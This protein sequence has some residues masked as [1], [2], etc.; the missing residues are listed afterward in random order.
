MSAPTNYQPLFSLGELSRA[1]IDFES[2]SITKDGTLFRS[3]ETAVAELRSKIDEVEKAV[4]KRLR[5]EEA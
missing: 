4:Q 1:L 5:Y 2:R 3:A